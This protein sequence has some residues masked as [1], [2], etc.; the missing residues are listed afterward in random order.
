MRRLIIIIIMGA[1]MSGLFLPN[2]CPDANSCIYIKA[3]HSKRGLMK[4]F[5]KIEN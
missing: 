1:Y 3:L 4:L 2:P 5:Q